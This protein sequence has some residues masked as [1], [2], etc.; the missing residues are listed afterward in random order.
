[1][2]A[3]NAAVR[4]F[5]CGAVPDGTLRQ[6]QSLIVYCAADADGLCLPCG[7]FCGVCRTDG[8]VSFAKGCFFLRKERFLCTD[9]VSRWRHCFLRSHRFFAGSEGCRDVSI[10]PVGVFFI[11][12]D[13]RPEKTVC[14]EENMK[15]IQKKQEI[16]HVGRK[17]EKKPGKNAG[18]TEERQ[19]KSGKTG[20]E[21]KEERKKAKKS[22]RKAK[23][24]GRVPRK[25]EAGEN[26]KATAEMPCKY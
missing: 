15:F 24:S 10:Y 25:K 11:H 7:A 3:A 22:G 14:Q 13:C 21:T 16:D 5:R 4:P 12:H 2:A 8:L 20:K 9:A 18:K 6:I 19:R 17:K 26:G 23:T 1:M